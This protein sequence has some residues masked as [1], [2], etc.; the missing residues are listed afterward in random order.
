[1]LREVISCLNL[2][3]QRNPSLRSDSDEGTVRHVR[4]PLLHGRCQSR[5]H[6]KSVTVRRPLRLFRFSRKLHQ[7]SHRRVHLR[8][9]N[10][11]SLL[12]LEM[13][14][15]SLPSEAGRGTIGVGTAELLEHKKL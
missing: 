13:L 1:M 4:H 6:Q 5:R 15:P 12:C 7:L 9:V 10:V 3:H 14:D 11:K 2:T 8:A